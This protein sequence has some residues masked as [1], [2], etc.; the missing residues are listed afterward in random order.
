MKDTPRTTYAIAVIL[1]KNGYLSEDNAPRE[2]VKLC[3]ALEKETDT[4]K[5]ALARLNNAAIARMSSDEPTGKECL[6]LLQA[7]KHAQE[8]LKN[9][10]P[11]PKQ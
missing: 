9:N 3:K 6:E 11:A 2:L 7:S 4:F 1:E 8:L 5:S 10:S